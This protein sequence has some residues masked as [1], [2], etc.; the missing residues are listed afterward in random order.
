MSTAVKPFVQF[1][2]LMLTVSSVL[3]SVTLVCDRLLALHTLYTVELSRLRDQD[4]LRERCKDPEFYH[5]MTKYSTLC[6]EVERNAMKSVFFSCLTR[7]LHETYLCGGRACVDYVNDSVVW[8]AN[9]SLP[10]LALVLVV[11]LFCPM[12]L[13]QLIRVFM[14]VMRPRRDYN[15]HYGGGFVYPAVQTLP[16]TFTPMIGDV[17]KLHSVVMRKG[18]RN[19]QSASSPFVRQYSPITEFED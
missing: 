1:T 14:E 7:V 13:L 11:A 8:V 15:Y 17:E 9:L 6:A 12:A 2:S 18:N 16:Q 19:N 10:M 5:N 3:W 4:W